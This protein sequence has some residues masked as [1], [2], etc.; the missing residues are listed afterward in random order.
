MNYIISIY[1]SK[2][3][4]KEIWMIWTSLHNFDHDRTEI[5]D[6]NLKIGFNIKGGATLEALASNP[7]SNPKSRQN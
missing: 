1:S 2:D 5:N 7:N 3:C 6:H 4:V